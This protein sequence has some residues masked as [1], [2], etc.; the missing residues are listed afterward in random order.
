MAVVAVHRVGA[1]AAIAVQ[2]QHRVALGF[3]CALEQL[4]GPH[5]LLAAPLAEVDHPVDL[6]HAAQLQ[7][8]LDAV[9]GAAVKDVVHQPRGHALKRFVRVHVAA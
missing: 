7:R 9:L 8:A 4:C 2:Q 6:L 5:R 1:V 3:Q